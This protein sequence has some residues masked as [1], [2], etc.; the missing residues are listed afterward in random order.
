MAPPEPEYLALTN[1]M[2]FNT[3]LAPET[4]NILPS[5]FA[6][7]AWPLPFMVKLLLMTMPVFATL[8]PDKRV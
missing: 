2:F 8:S 4:E 6:S 7:I 1:V 5:S 3:T